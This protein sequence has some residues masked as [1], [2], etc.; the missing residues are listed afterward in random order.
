MLAPV[1][2]ARS[3]RLGSA[4][5]AF[6]ALAG[7]LATTVSISMADPAAT[8]PGADRAGAEQAV[9]HGPVGWESYRN[10]ERLVEIG[11]D[12]RTKQFSSFD[13]A[14]YNRD[15]VASCLRTTEEGCVIAEHTGPGEIDSIWF[16]RDG[17]DVTAT[18]NIRIELDGQPPIVDAPLQ[19][20][21]N[22][23]LGKPFEYPLVANRE[24]SSGGVY[25]KV[26][27]TFRESMRITTDADPVFSHVTYREFASA[28][29]ITTFD[30]AD[31]AADVFDKLAASGTADPKPEQPNPQTIE[32]PI[33]VAAGETVT[34]AET[35]EP[36]AL[37]SLAFQIPQLGTTPES[38]DILR[39]ARLRIGFDGE[40]TVDAPLGEFFGSGFG[41]AD[42]RSFM[43]GMDPATKTLSSWWLMP[44]AESA[45]VELYNGSGVAIS[46]GQ[47]TVGT[48][49]TTQWADELAAG[50]AGHFRT[51]SV[52]EETELR[53]DYVLMDTAGRGQVVGVTQSAE[54][55]DGSRSHVEGDER[56]F[57][58][59]SSS[60]DL[61]G[62]G[63]EDFFEGGWYFNNGTFTN[64]LNGNPISTDGGATGCS[65]DCFGMYRLLIAEGIDFSSDIRFSAEHGRVNHIP[66]VEGSTTYWYGEPTGELA[67]TDTLDV[68]NTNSEN[69][70]G[71]TSDTPGEITELTSGF[72]GVDHAS[73]QPVTLD[74]RATAAEVSFRMA[75]SPAN[76]GVQLR[77]ISNQT[78]GFQA[79][80]VTVDGEPAGTWTQPLGNAVRRWL[81]DSYQ[82]PASLT[83]G[84]EELTITLTPAAGS[85]AWSAAA[86]HALSRVPNADNGA[87]PDQVAGLA[88]TPDDFT[89]VNLSWR[90]ADDD[91]Y[92]PRY[93]VHASKTK[94]FTP[95]DQTLVG[96]TRAPGFAHL[97]LDVG[98]TWHYRVRAVDAA[99]NA[100]PYS[101]ETS[102]TTGN[103]MRFEAE[104]MTAS[105]AGRGAE[106]QGNC[107]D[108]VFSNDAQLWFRAT[109]AGQAM[110][111]EFEIPGETDRRY[112]VKIAQT[113]AGDYGI[114]QISLNGTAIGTPF[115][116]Y[117]TPVQVT[118]PMDYGTYT[119]SPGVH[120]LTVDITGKN[121]S[122]TGYM[123]GLDYIHLV[124][125]E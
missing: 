16:T 11:T 55:V 47:S 80:G 44:Y 39:N 7:V 51:T 75:V 48:S 35:S 6:V 74:A 1:R 110:T 116:A 70:H 90:Q 94:G 76:Q 36:G 67:W 113:K 54:G 115:D 3:R 119:L 106:G 2:K 22:G 88:A 4:G 62:T 27:M 42:V 18:G 32:Q 101:A 25:I 9:R 20:V 84:K 38:D 79:A 29:G 59:G 108:A 73:P 117:A 26:P 28:A 112:A 104:R 111:A 102:A 12:S 30:P 100:G 71:Y 124:P 64:P 57:V 52:R 37:T 103:V 120:T 61:H 98:E 105:G 53:K 89:N 14:G 31:P 87:A 93:E 45:T 83:A 85:P 49:A 40:Q 96:S 33:D 82:L 72:E 8:T 109:G 122:S 24:Q 56:I 10:P 118:E 121:G 97:E 91:V 58:D 99:E 19:D 78:K 43:F 17:G 92:A 41:L 5:L 63:T 68:G 66:A 23:T 65:A 77:R 81:D 34:M 123:A 15:N 86:Y 125:A 13:R 114:N 95:S 50:R 46:G 107:C 69:A 60:P 21:V